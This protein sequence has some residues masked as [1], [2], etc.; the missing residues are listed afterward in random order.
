M[1]K[2]KIIFSLTTR[3][4]Y[5]ELFNL[6]LAHVYARHFGLQL[7][8]N[9]WLWNFRL[10][11]GWE[12]YFEPVIKN[13]NNPL[14]AQD[15]VYTKERPWIGKIYYKP[16]E[17]FTFYY[18]VLVNW[19]YTLFH[20]NTMLTKDIFE[21][22][23]SDKFINNVL[24]KDAFA[25]L[26]EAYKNIYILNPETRKLLDNAKQAL[27]LPDKYIGVHIRR[28][29]KITSEEMKAI[30]NDK[31]INE[32]LKH[33]ELCKTIYIA[34]DDVS[35]IDEFITILEPNGIK[36][37]YNKFNNS[38]GYDLVKFNKA[39]KNTRREEA[40]NVLLD[41]DI[42]IHSTFFIGTYTS[43]LS[44]VVPFYLGQENCVSLDNEWNIINSSNGL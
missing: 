33:S 43:N 11:K 38:K 30:H 4:F 13:S 16:N 9:S 6:S 3:G 36:V 18:R 1:K 37:Y 28:G 15:N 40:I 34:T 25:L 17:F 42:L 8:I 12:D 19:L 5:S 10:D 24:G 35:I 29:D 41:M 20:P 39:E 26:S 7:K 14:S 21:D 22:M 23:R 27:S 44:R 2:S 31:Y 32:I